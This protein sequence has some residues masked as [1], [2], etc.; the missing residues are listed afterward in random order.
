M[1]YDENKA[2]KEKQ[3][4]QKRLWRINNPEK[5]R[6]QNRKAQAKY[7]E[8]MRPIWIA[9]SII[10]REKYKLTHQPISSQTL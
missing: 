5:N 3:N 4:E 1:D 9:E 7:K 10:K 8:K 6:E 2:R